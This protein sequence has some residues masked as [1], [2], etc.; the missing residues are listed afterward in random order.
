MTPENKQLLNAVSIIVGTCIGAGFLGIP[1]VAAQSG[2]FVAFAYM[3]ILG[4]IILLINLYFGEII[5]RTRTDRQMIGYAEK[6]LGERGS[7]LMRGAVMFSIYSAL[8]A[9]MIGI[10]Q[11]FSFLVFGNMDYGIHTGAIFGFIMSYLLLGGV[12]SLKTYEKAGIMTIFGLFILTFF[13]YIGKVDFTNFFYVNETQIFLPIGVILFSLIEFYALPE[14][15]VVLQNHENLLKKAII[16][17]TI[18]PIIFYALFAFIVVGFKGTYTPEIST[19][20]LGNIFVLVGMLAM[21]TSYLSLGTSLMD[22]YKNDLNMTK[23]RAWFYAAIFPILIF[24]VLSMFE[25]LS[26]VNILSVGGVIA[27]GIMVMMVLIISERSKTLGNRTP[28]YN[29]LINNFIVS[30]LSLVFLLGIILELSR[31]I[32]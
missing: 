15:R 30:I 25:F 9:Y 27:G 19:F 28:E 13:M 31:F 5:L 8:L 29:I 7:K 10:G 14:V 12:R 6:Y 23:N 22:S 16:L 2:F 11:S 3:I 1:Y 26:F 17:G 21:F 24:L 18:I 32:I 4:L 20:A